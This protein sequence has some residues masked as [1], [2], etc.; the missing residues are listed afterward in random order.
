MTRAR[1]LA[2]ITAALVVAMVVRT[3][4]WD[5]IDRRGEVV[6]DPRRPPVLR[7]G[8]GMLLLDLETRGHSTWTAEMRCLDVG[9]GAAVVDPRR[10]RSSIEP[11]LVLLPA[12]TYR[13]VLDGMP[14]AGERGYRNE[15][16]GR[17]QSVVTIRSGEDT[18]LEVR[19]PVGAR[20]ILMVVD[21]ERALMRPRTEENASRPDGVYLEAGRPDAAHE[22]VF[23][24][25]DGDSIR[26][27]PGD[28]GAWSFLTRS[29][30][31]CRRATSRWP[32]LLE[33][34]RSAAFR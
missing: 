15:V 1:V 18:R 31:R 28:R 34:A 4:P 16:C 5:G 14:R 26:S 11:T 21:A 8:E 24:R 20:L 19:E 25:T 17:C 9:T 33:A 7:D 13:V 12:G 6:V 27:A 23:F 30:G 32:R 10:V 2:L 3:R 29:R 22:V